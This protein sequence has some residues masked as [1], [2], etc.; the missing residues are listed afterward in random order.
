MNGIK[1]LRKNSNLINEISY[2]LALGFKTIG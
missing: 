1:E 2:S